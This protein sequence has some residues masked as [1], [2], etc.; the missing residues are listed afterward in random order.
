MSDS[1]LTL[2]EVTAHI[3]AHASGADLTRI[4]EVVKERRKALATMAAARVTVGAEV[5]IANISPTYYTG[6]RGTVEAIERGA[7]RVKFNAESTNE[8]RFARSRKISVPDCVAEWTP[9]A[10]FPLTCLRVID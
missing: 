1:R 8:L 9:L 4:G 10:M 6:K 2:P 5:E 3:A 7:A